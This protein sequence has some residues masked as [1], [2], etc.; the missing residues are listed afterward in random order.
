MFI[1]ISNKLVFSYCVTTE[2]KINEANDNREADELQ[3]QT[4]RCSKKL[5]VVPLYAGGKKCRC[6][7]VKRTILERSH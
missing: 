2:M 7:A 4:G 6:G 1:S 3:R 5:D